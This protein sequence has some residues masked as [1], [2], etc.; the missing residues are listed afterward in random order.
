MPA[1]SASTAVS[2]STRQQRISL[3]PLDAMTLHPADL[4]DFELL[5]ADAADH[6]NAAIAERSEDPPRRRRRFEE[7]GR[8]DGFAARFTPA[9]CNSGFDA[10]IVVD[11]I[12]A[13]FTRGAGALQALTDDLA[14][15]DLPN[16]SRLFPRNI[17]DNT[18]CVHLLFDED[19]VRFTLY[20]VDFR[21]QN[22][23]GSVGVVW[24]WPHGGPIQ[25]LKLAERQAS[26][27]RTAL[28][29]ESAVAAR[30]G[31]AVQR[32]ERQLSM[33]GEA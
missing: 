27:I 33:V 28:R 16:A 30:S 1:T 20:R 7:W 5:F 22:I 24:R 2:P 3:P 10:P 29:F 11:S 23:L 13:R 32:K 25:A 9:S 4:P 18:E 8:L 6:T 12:V 17:A 21:V 15:A 31:E 19:G 26:R 14:F